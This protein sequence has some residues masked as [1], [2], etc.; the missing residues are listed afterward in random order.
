MIPPKFQILF[1]NLIGLGWSFYLSHLANAPAA[2]APRAAAPAA[3]PPA[4][5]ATASSTT[6][7][8]AKMQ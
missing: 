3:L 8:S 7:E 2:A 1:S 6:R 5:A 4:A